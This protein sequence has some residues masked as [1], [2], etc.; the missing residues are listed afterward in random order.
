MP[1]EFSIDKEN[2]LLER[3]VTGKVTPEEVIASLEAS[4]SHPDYLPGMRSLTDMRDF[5]LSSTAEDIRQYATFLGAHMDMI[6]GMQAAVVVSRTVDYG[7]TRMLQAIADDPTFA[8]AV[9]YDIDEAKRWLEAVRGVGAS[10]SAGGESPTGREPGAR[11]T[12]V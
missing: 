1:V 4:I 9:F 10:A 2:E 5:V 12:A 11:A 3:T 8:I 6:K 7:L